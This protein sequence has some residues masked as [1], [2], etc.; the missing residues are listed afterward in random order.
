VLAAIAYSGL[1]SFALLKA[2]ALVVPLRVDAGDESVGLDLTQHGEEAYMH[3]EGS[4]A[5][6]ASAPSHVFGAHHGLAESHSA[7]R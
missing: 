5:M 2:I 7:A 4:S 6:A 1:V 3:A